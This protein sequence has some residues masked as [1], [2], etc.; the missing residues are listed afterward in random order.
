MGGFTYI[1]CVVVPLQIIAA[2]AF[3]K[4]EDGGYEFTQ[5]IV[6]DVVKLL[7][8]RMMGAMTDPAVIRPVLYLCISGSYASEAVCLF[9]GSLLSPT[10]FIGAAVL[11]YSVLCC[12]VL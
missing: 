4:D 8:M 7:L 6:Q 10:M 5:D 9:V 3:G 1:S 12:V 11:C 2:L